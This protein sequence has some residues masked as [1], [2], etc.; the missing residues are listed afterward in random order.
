MR[1]SI[2][3][4]RFQRWDGGIIYFTKNCGGECEFYR[5]I[6]DDDLCGWG[7]AFKYLTKREKQRKCEI[8]NRPAKDEIWPTHSVKYLDSL[9]RRLNGNS[10]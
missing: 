6:K 3:K 10:S 9:I 7:I 2:P 4:R 5:K 8:K 1:D